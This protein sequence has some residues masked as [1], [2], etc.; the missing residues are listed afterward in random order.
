MRDAAV[1]SAIG[2]D[3]RRRVLGVSCAISEAEVHWRVFLESLA[4][5]MRGV[6]YIVSDDHWGP[7]ARPSSAAPAGAL[8]VPPGSERHP[9]RPQSRHPQAYRK[10]AAPG[11]GRRRPQGR[12]GRAGAPGWTTPHSLKRCNT[13]GGHHVTATSCANFQTAIKALEAG[14]IGDTIRVTNSYSRQTIEAVITR[15]GEVLARPSGQLIS[16]RR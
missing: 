13:E 15:P 6:A 8:P 12:R 5:G 9:P 1:L 16:Q 3:Q 10:G 11:L 4:R 14:A 2:I 7:R